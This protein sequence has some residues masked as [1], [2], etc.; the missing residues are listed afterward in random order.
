[1]KNRATLGYEL[2]EVKGQAVG[3]TKGE[4]LTTVRLEREGKVAVKVE[5]VRKIEIG[6]KS[7]PGEEKGREEEREGGRGEWGKVRS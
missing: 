7:P 2:H 1:M 6:K 4:R 5:I 3:Y